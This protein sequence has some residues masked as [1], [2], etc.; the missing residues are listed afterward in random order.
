MVPPAGGSVTLT[1]TSPFASSKRV[2]VSGSVLDP[3]AGQLLCDGTTWSLVSG[4]TTI[5]NGMVPTITSQQVSV[6]AR[7]T[8]VLT[9]KDQSTLGLNYSTT[10]DQTNVDLSLSVAGAGPSVSITSPANGAS[11]SSESFA[12]EASTAS[13]TARRSRC[14]CAAAAAVR[15][16]RR[17]QRSR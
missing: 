7:G 9:V 1:W 16:P 4:S 17:P 5:D 14:G 10:C 6:P 3:N 11:A 13:G 15:A 8:I 2:T 12:G